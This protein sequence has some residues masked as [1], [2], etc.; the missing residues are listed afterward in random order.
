M[1]VL[2][3]DGLAPSGVK[4]LEQNG[5]EVITENVPQEKLAQKINEEHY[6]ALLVRSATKVRKEL[7]DQ[8]PNL[9]FIGRGGVGMDNIDVD[10][11]RE[12]GIMV[13]NTPAASSQ[14][15]GELVIG[16]MFSLARNVYESNRNMPENGA[17]NFKALKKQ[18]SKGIELR[19]KTLGLIGFGRIGKS[20]ASYAIG[21]GM[22]IVYHDPFIDDNSVR[23]Y[24]FDGQEVEVSVEKMELDELLKTS[25]FISLHIPAQDDGKPVISD[26]EFEMMKEG[27]IIV[28]AARGGVID[29]DALIKYLDNGKVRAAALDVFVNEPNPR[30]ELLAHSKIGA[31][32]HIGAATL[33][34]QSR[35]GTELA[36]K[37]ITHFGR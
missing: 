16:L 5:F 3:N 28:N 33:E 30:K 7:I 1:R 17:N 18:Y 37:I 25:D 22:R 23:I 4:M 32:P 19:G 29:E 13:A 34:A 31:T 8:C 9:K 14:S 11:A 36:E 24:L 20:A 15:V 26:A 10:Y 6:V 35:I 2:A 21:G 12:K 27:V